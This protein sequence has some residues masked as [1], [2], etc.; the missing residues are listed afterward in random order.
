[1]KKL[2]FLLFCVL[3]L[4]CGPHN[5]AFAVEVPTISDSETSIPQDEMSLYSTPV[6]SDELDKSTTSPEELPQNSSDSEN[7]TGISTNDSGQIVVDLTKIKEVHFKDEKIEFVDLS[8]NTAVED[9]PKAGC[10]FE[11]PQNSSSLIQI[12]EDSKNSGTYI[13]KVERNLDLD[14]PSFSAFSANGVLQFQF[15]GRASLSGNIS[16]NQIVS[17][18]TISIEGGTV[19]VQKISASNNIEISSCTSVS[20]NEIFSN[21]NLTVIG[22]SKLFVTKKDDTSYGQIILKGDLQLGDLQLDKDSSVIHA[23]GNI[24][25]L[26]ISI[27]SGTLKN[28]KLLKASDMLNIRSSGQIQGNGSLQAREI[29]AEG[30]VKGSD[31][32]VENHIEIGNNMDLSGTLTSPSLTVNGILN[33]ENVKVDTDIIV[34]G[35][36]GVEGNV[37]ASANIFVNSQLHAKGTVSVGETISVELPTNSSSDDF[38]STRKI[39]AKCLKVNRA[40][41]LPNCE[42]EI[43]S[44]GTQ[45]QGE[46]QA[47]GGSCQG[48]LSASSVSFSEIFQ[49]SSITANPG[50]I[51]VQQ[52]TLTGDIRS[53]NGVI[54]NGPV[55]G[56]SILV[57]SGDI[58]AKSNA[59][60][61]L[62]G[63][64]EAPNGSVYLEATSK[65]EG[66]VYGKSGVSLNDGDYGSID[67]EGPIKLRGDINTGNIQAGTLIIDGQIN[68]DTLTCKTGSLQKNSVLKC[69]SLT[70]S[71]KFTVGGSITASKAFKGSPIIKLSSGT[72]NALSISGLEN[73]YKGKLTVTTPFGSNKNV[74]I[75]LKRSETSVG[76]YNLKTD[77]NGR[78]SVENLAPGNY[79][80]YVESGSNGRRGTVIVPSSG[81]VYLDLRSTAGTSSGGQ[82][83][84]GDDFFDEDEFWEDVSD[85]IRFAKKGD[86]V[87]VNATKTDTVPVWLLQDLEGRPITLKLIHGRDSVTIDGDNMYE[88]PNNRVYYVFEDLADLYELPP[89]DSNHTSSSSHSHTQVSSSS[90]SA[91]DVR[92]SQTAS[93]LPIYS[94]PTISASSTAWTPTGIGNTDNNIISTGNDNST[95]STGNNDI[96]TS[97]KNESE[98]EPEESSD[99]ETK[100]LDPEDKD[101]LLNLEPS[102][103]EEPPAEAEKQKSIVP[104]IIIGLVLLALGVTSIGYVIYQNSRANGRIDIDDNEENDTYQF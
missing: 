104:W 61:N 44:G 84:G 73:E 31:L 58:I 32:T 81:T 67:S 59:P 12:S 102:E 45:I 85:R 54:L 26:N 90:S 101:V 2:P 92:P 93:S 65:I 80:V 76:G 69:N 56:K 40:L 70:S 23:E 1:M 48:P 53:K 41:I 9:F 24:E 25:A 96:V 57:E 86:I 47:L 74:Y 37:N 18:G 14:V 60:I 20:T 89:D 34:N 16:A 88:I 51:D 42:L 6:S 103:N 22:D 99:S 39:K 28:Q 52:V 79:S 68:A 95:N 4:S 8:N 29:S 10:V 62:S 15:S 72:I 55:Q 17:Q 91:P 98:K 35:Q 19:E 3:F 36:L 7:L 100:I 64:I 13:Y 21:C 11:K 82:T 27:D 87:R 46:L 5:L 33:V 94:Q 71:G 30:P 43:G 77:A 63:S 38:F 75:E 97:S 50:G 78:I 83:T 49:G 66:R